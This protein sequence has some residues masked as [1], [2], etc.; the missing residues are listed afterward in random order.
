MD[1]AINTTGTP[2]TFDLA[3]DPKD[4]NKEYSNYFCHRNETIYLNI[5][6]GRGCSDPTSD[7][8]PSLPSGAPN[9]P[10]K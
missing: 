2:R 5:C 4:P 9:P 10:V 3:I 6:D 7:W 1:T 8:K